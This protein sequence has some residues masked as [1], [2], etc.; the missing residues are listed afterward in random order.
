[1]TLLCAVCVAAEG[2]TAVVYAAEDLLTG[3]PVALKVCLQSTWLHIHDRAAAGQKLAY[4]HT[5]AMNHGPVMS[6]WLHVWLIDSLL[7]G[8]LLSTRKLAYVSYVPNTA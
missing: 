3:R 4:L 6:Q 7:A 2:A 1:L 8:V 5:D